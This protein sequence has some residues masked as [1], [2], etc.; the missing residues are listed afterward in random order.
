MPKRAK[1]AGRAGLEKARRPEKEKRG[2]EGKGDQAKSAR[3][4]KRTEPSTAGGKP[5]SGAKT[6]GEPQTANES[7][8]GLDGELDS[9]MGEFDE[10]I[11]REQ[12]LLEQRR[13]PPKPRLPTQRE[14]PVRRCPKE[15][16]RSDGSPVEQTE[17]SR[18]TDARAGRDTGGS[19]DA[20]SGEEVQ[21]EP[22]DSDWGN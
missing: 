12:E 4:S 14:V 10:I 20:P 19:P 15:T 3:S 2:T 21:P 16:L 18:Q 7:Q 1:R 13:K 6:G 8:A 5:S 9:A 22:R 11:L 17:P